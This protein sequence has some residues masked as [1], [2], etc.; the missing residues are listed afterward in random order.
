MCVN[1]LGPA[2]DIGEDIDNKTPT[3]FQSFIGSVA[4]KLLE[5]LIDTYVYVGTLE[6]GASYI[7]HYT[8]LTCCF[9]IFLMSLS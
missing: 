5:G 2:V 8:L 3:M 7:R 4:Y 6:N 1:R 9:P